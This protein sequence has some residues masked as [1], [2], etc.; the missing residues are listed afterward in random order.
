MILTEFTLLIIGV[1]FIVLALLSI[2]LYFIFRNVE[3]L[4]RGIGF[5][6]LG[7]AHMAAVLYH[8]NIINGFFIY[9][10][11]P[12]ALENPAE[13]VPFIGVESIAFR[14]PP[15]LLFYYLKSAAQ[16]AIYSPGTMN[17]WLMIGAK[18][19]VAL[20][21]IALAYL[22]EVM[23]L[24]G[25]WPRLAFTGVIALLNVV[26]VVLAYSAGSAVDGPVEAGE[27]G[28]ILIRANLSVALQGI[29]GLIVVGVIAYGVFRIFKET[30]ERSYLVQAASWGIF[31]L[32]IIP[33]TILGSSLASNIALEAARSEA[34]RILLGAMLIVATLATLVASTLLIL[35]AIL[36]LLPTGIEE[37]LEEEVEEEVGG[38]AVTEE[39]R[40]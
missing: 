26:A 22:A 17:F 10:Q 37:E 35:G 32:L 29:S 38:E 24:A 39:G 28:Q 9:E 12:L 3:N 21:L 36:E 5:A 13:W 19:L 2:T 34:A 16:P 27:V 18:A 20:G 4:L 25:R 15:T 40:A 8:S 30:G 14:G 31:A 11:A 23:V 33:A 1:T 6:A 7:L